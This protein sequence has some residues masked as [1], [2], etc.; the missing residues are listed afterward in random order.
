MTMTI[1]LRFLKILQW[2]LQGVSHFTHPFSQTYIDA[3]GW[4]C[5]MWH[6]SWH[7]LYNCYK[8][9]TGFIGSKVASQC[10]TTLPEPRWISEHFEATFDPI[11]WSLYIISSTGT[12]YT[13]TPICSFMQNWNRLLSSPV[14]IIWSYTKSPIWLF[15]TNCHQLLGTPVGFLWSYTPA[16]LLSFTQNW[17]HLLG[18]PVGIFSYTPTPI[19]AFTQNWHKLLGTPGE[20]YFSNQALFNFSVRQPR[21]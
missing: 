6:I 7:T 13:P 5:Q 15:M 21:K 14:G 12:S 16:P 17:H 4:V 10:S 1:D 3:A 2:F 18:T 19:W 9:D 20:I 11:P 8:Y